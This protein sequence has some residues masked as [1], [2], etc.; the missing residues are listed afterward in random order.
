MATVLL[1]VAAVK[2]KYLYIVYQSHNRASPRP[3][4]RLS[5]SGGSARATQARFQ[6]LKLAVR[7]APGG[8]ATRSKRLKS[9]R[10][11]GK[12]P[13]QPPRTST[14]PRKDFRLGGDGPRR[15]EFQLISPESKLSGQVLTR[16]F[17]GGLRC[18]FE[19]N[20]RERV[21]VA[22]RTPLPGWLGRAAHRYLRKLP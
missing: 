13:H 6:P 19:A 1:P 17:P 10:Q 3:S 15:V 12:V 20:W 4:P 18:E 2:N 9:P 16:Q 8:P 11:P 21:R 22:N 14:Q 7:R 5:A